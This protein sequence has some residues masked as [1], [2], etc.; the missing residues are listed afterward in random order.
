M[1]ET[2]LCSP[3]GY[4][5]GM[6]KKLF[7]TVLGLALLGASGPVSAGSLPEPQDNTC[8]PHHLT[9]IDDLGRVTCQ[10][11]TSPNCS[12]TGE[13]CEPPPSACDGAYCPQLMKQ[14]FQDFL[15]LLGLSA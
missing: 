13:G 14:L 10:K 2:T 15:D 12:G 5:Q 9:V 1:L 8:P 3:R 6:L 4:L 7:P 11:I